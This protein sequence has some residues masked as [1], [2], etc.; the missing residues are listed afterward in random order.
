M[1]VIG[2]CGRCGGPVQVPEL[3]GGT[4]PPV[5]ACMSCGSTAKYPY[6]PT[7]PM[8][9]NKNIRHLEIDWCGGTKGTT[10]AH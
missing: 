7:I 4:V 10:N 5:P 1:A 6:G 9:G 2:T 3:W 8:D